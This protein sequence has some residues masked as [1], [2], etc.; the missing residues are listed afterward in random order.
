MR[1]CELTQYCVDD[2]TQVLILIGELSILPIVFD[3]L[4]LIAVSHS[5]YLFCLSVVGNIDYS[6]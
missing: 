4:F 5:E 1:A 2:N 6:S 3:H